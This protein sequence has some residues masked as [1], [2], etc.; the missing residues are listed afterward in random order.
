MEPITRIRKYIV[1]LLAICL[2]L[3]CVGCGRET[4]QSVQGSS[5]PNVQEAE[6]V[7]DPE[8]QTAAEQTMESLT[9]LLALDT[10]VAESLELSDIREF[11]GETVVC[12]TQSW[13]GVEVYG[14][15]ITV[16]A[17]GDGWC[18]GTVY[19]FS[20][21]EDD[22][23]DTLVAQAA[24]EPEWF[25]EF[26]EYGTAVEKDSLHPV[27]Y[28]TV[29]GE[30]TLARCFI[31]RDESDELVY[32]YELVTSLDGS[33]LYSYEPLFTYF[34]SATVI[35]G[36]DT[37][38]VIRE[39]GLMYAYNEEYNVFVLAEI[40]NDDD[41]I[42]SYLTDSGA[43]LSLDSVYSDSS[44]KWDSGRS[45]TVFSD[46]AVFLD[47]ASWYDEC[48]GWH[49]VDSKGGCAMLISGLKYE[50]LGSPAANWGERG[51]VFL[52]AVKDD[53]KSVKDAPEILAHEFSHALLKNMV[54]LSNKNESGS[55]HEALSD[56][57][58]SLY[59]GDGTWKIGYGT[60]NGRDLSVAQL[61][62]DDD[63]LYD[64]EYD[65]LNEK[66][67]S[68]FLKWA[69]E[70]L[71]KNPYTSN[72]FK[73]NNSMIVS[74]CLH[75]IW[76]NVF[77]KD[78]DSFGQV[79]F[80]SLRYMTENCDFSEYRDCFL[81]AMRQN[82]SEAET[83]RASSFFDTAGI[84]SKGAAHIQQLRAADWS[85]N[86]DSSMLELVCMTYGE[87]RALGW[88][89]EYVTE[90]MNLS[91]FWSVRFE[92]EGMAVSCNFY[93]SEKGTADA[94]P[95]SLIF[96]SFGDRIY[97]TEG[98]TTG[99]SYQEARSA[100][101]TGALSTIEAMESGFC[102]IMYPE[103]GIRIVLFL[104]GNSATATITGGDISFFE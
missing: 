10:S 9:E 43:R 35:S 21:L 75:A 23:F 73:Y 47:V 101:P 3:T 83:A 74:T 12:Y 62:M 100:D 89:A 2:V 103:Q 78:D 22:G 86:K 90:S 63:F 102:A 44:S 80:H 77:D 56:V 46:L 96:D 54:H 55:L 64:Y 31:V 27:I 79:V 13:R 33:I 30:G 45:A 49:G 91:G 50:T 26:A 88:D 16:S 41:T 71:Q 14:S 51:Y 72:K 6:P 97:I 32:R 81:F 99:M 20:D 8:Q 65:T 40:T 59:K 76:E 67:A 7:Q 85:E 58:A 104:D 70:K 15:A 66:E 42:A 61:N 39:N 36:G 52:N 18:S 5:M 17:D 87:L 4:T 38:E 98:I 84:K 93:G 24:E 28:I 25:A 34:S 60:G 92:R 29:Y 48:F 68:V 82:Y 19:D 57:F 95:S 1:V 94:Y 69:Q 37:L 53:G 11:D